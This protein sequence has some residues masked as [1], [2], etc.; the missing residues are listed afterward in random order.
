MIRSMKT[1]GQALS[2][3]AHLM[4]GGTTAFMCRTDAQ[5]EDMWARIEAILTPYGSASQLK[6]WKKNFACEVL[7]DK[8]C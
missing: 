8:K 2:I 5:G 1:Q 6:K 7:E 4:Q 3:A